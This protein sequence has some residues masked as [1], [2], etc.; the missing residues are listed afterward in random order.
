[1]RQEW[2]EDEGVVSVVEGEN[3]GVVVN[4]VA[5]EWWCEDGGGENGCVKMVVMK[6]VVCRW[7]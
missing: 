4:M 6:M 1:M 7:W 5:W 3:G 2:K